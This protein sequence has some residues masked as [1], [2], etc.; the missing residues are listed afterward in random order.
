PRRQ[1]LTTERTRPLDSSLPERR[2]CTS[3]GDTANAFTRA[4]NGS[5]DAVS[6][7]D[8]DEQVREVIEVGALELQLPN[9]EVETQQGG[10]GDGNANA[11]SNQRVADGAG[12][13]IEARRTGAAN[14]LERMHDAPHRAKQADE[15][16]GGSDAG[17][18]RQAT[19]RGA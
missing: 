1:S 19:L 3:L 14:A 2:G 8:A 10:D 12:D 9:E 5:F 6:Q 17:Q 18:N 4:C 7:R 13:D 11:G 16:R 15:R